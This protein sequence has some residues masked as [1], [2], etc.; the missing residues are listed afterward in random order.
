MLTTHKI[1]AELYFE[2]F[3]LLAVHTALEDYAIAYALNKHLKLQLYRTGQDM[4]L[5]DSIS[6][7]LFEWM[8]ELSDTHWSL[9]KNHTEQEQEA[10]LGGLFENDR[11]MSMGYLVNELKEVDYFLKIQSD[12]AELAN[13]IVSEVNKIPNVIT[14]YTIDVETLQSR[15]NLIV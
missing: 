10:S 9:F 12:G 4:K 11:S 1:S 13:H 7:S 14:A 6:F 3:E 2:T 15:K 5:N 8:D